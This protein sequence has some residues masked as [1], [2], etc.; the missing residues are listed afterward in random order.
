MICFTGDG[1]FYYHISEL[2]TALRFGINTVTIVNNNSALAQCW[3][4]VKKVFQ[5][6]P[7]KEK[8]CMF[9]A[10]SKVSFAKVAE[11]FGCIGMRIERPDEIQPAIKT[12]LQADRPVVIE[13]ITDPNCVAPDARSSSAVRSK[14]ED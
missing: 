11:G 12:A 10:P 13:L 8:F 9:S 4:S 6:H 14:W 7:R 5:N 2:E 3:T 1:G